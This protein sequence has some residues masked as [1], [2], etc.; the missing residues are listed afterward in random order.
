LADIAQKSYSNILNELLQKSQEERA[1]SSAATPSLQL[2]T[3][4]DKTYTFNSKTGQL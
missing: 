2:T 3:I 1:S 4:G